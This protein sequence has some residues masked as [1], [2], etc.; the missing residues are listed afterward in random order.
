MLVISIRNWSLKKQ[1][2]KRH[3]ASIDVLVKGPQAKIDNKST[4]YSDND[5]FKVEIENW[6]SYEIKIFT[7]F[8]GKVFESTNPEDPWNG[9]LNNTGADLPAG[10]YYVVIT[11]QLRGEPEKTY[12]G[13]LTLIR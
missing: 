13:T 6:T 4:G 3:N 1:I 9:K 7:R 10:V 2:V 11:Y 8:S 12:N 5:N